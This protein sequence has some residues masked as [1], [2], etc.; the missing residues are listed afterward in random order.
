MLALKSDK[1]TASFRR[2]LVNLCSPEV[3]F[4][5]N[6]III[7][8]IFHKLNLIKL[9]SLITRVHELKKLRRF[10]VYFYIVNY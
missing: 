7:F 5:I 1:K 10:I 9:E 3:H 2:T 6:L 4:I 8:Q